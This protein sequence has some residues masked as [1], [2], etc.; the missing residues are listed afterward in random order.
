MPLSTL[1]DIKN[2]QTPF[3]LI[4]AIPKIKCLNK[5]ATFAKG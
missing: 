1:L 4:I 5:M 3:F 2:T